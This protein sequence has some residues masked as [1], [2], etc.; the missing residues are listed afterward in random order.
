MKKVFVLILSVSFL[1]CAATSSHAQLKFHGVKIKVAEMNEALGFYVEKLGFKV[2]SS[3]GF[4][5]RVVLKTNSFPIYLELAERTNKSEYPKEART[6]LTLQTNKLL[7]K[8]D[9]LREK[10]IEFHEPYL[11]KNGVGIAIPFKDPF[12]NVLSLMEVQVRDI[13]EFEEPRVYNAGVTILDMDSAIGFYTSKLGFQ[14]WSRN[15]LPDALPLKHTEGSFAFM[16]HYKEGLIPSSI[17]YPQ[18]TQTIL[19]FETPDLANTKAELI[20]KGVTV[21]HSKSDKQFAIADLEGNVL[22]VIENKE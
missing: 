20:R 11:S 13:P 18:E 17:D 22:E 5:N 1:L 10:G 21:I 7:L 3:D 2:D 19:V 4:P 14:E 12:G 15:Y 8:I 16:I 6:G 9:E